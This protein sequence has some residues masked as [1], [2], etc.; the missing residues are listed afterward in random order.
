M[1]RDFEYFQS[2][3]AEGVCCDQEYP[4]QSSHV[5]ERLVNILELWIQRSY[6]KELELPAES[7]Q[8]DPW[9]RWLIRRWESPDIFSV[10]A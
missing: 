6:G 2:V 5:L 8:G 9:Q 1:T 7:Q 3:G 10:S 4:Y